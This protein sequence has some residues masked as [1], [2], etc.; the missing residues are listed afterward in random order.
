MTGIRD[1]SGNGIGVIADGARTSRSTGVRTSDVTPS[2]SSDFTVP[3]RALYIGGE[4][5]V[6]IKDLK[7]NTRTFAGLSSGTI[8]DVQCTKVFSTDTTAT[9]IVALY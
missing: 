6:K 2:D 3:A 5:D 1:K 8:L 7:G 9:D 4:G